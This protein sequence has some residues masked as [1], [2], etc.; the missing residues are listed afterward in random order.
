MISQ[1]F[2]VNH[3]K[4]YFEEAYFSLEKQLV[5][6]RLKLQ[7]HHSV[8]ESSNRSCWSLKVL[9]C[10]FRE[11]MWAFLLAY[12]QY[13]GELVTLYTTL[14]SLKAEPIISNEPFTPVFT[15]S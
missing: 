1:V 14:I 8:F 2:I 9:G 5:T 12:T 3:E 13:V 7:I 6:E 11:G 15:A 10:T 4:N